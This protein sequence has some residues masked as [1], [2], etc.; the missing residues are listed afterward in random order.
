MTLS[1]TPYVLTGIY[2][3]PSGVGHVSGY[4]IDGSEGFMLYSGD[5]GNTWTQ[6]Y[7]SG[8]SNFCKRVHDVFMY[9]DDLGK[10][11]AHMKVL[12]TTNGGGISTGVP[13]NYLNIGLY[14]N[15]AVDVIRVRSKVV[16]EDYR[17][18]TLDG[19]VVRSGTYQPDTRIEVT[20]L[21]P[22]MYVLRLVSGA[23]STRAI[24]VRS[25]E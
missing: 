14:P 10:A 19:K 21:K 3:G 23:A 2:F 20:D 6:N 11:P 5:G 18:L 1:G 25:L 16:Y 13:E 7:S 17:I 15:P 8:T 9:D 22:G 4:R 12:T 24:F